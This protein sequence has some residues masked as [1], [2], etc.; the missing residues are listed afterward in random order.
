MPAQKPW[1][2][3]IVQKEVGDIYTLNILLRPFGQPQL[4]P[5]HP[6]HLII[7]GN[8]E[9]MG[10]HFGPTIKLSKDGKHLNIQLAWSLV[11]AIVLGADTKKLGFITRS[12]P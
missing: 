5:D 11:V 1:A 6:E 7:L 3:L 4:H 8:I 9:D 2:I 12:E 10:H